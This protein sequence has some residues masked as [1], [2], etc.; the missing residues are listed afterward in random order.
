[1]PM[2]TAISIAIYGIKNTKMPGRTQIC[3]ETRENLFFIAFLGN[4]F[5]SDDAVGVPAL[6]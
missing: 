6:S 1:M 2:P 5:L 4:L 3:N